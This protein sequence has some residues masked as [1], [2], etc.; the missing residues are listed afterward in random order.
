M[1]VEF[2]TGTKR[3]VIKG[4]RSP[5]AGGRPGEPPPNVLTTNVFLLLTIEVTGEILNLKN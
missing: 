3:K 1:I 4:R 5:G 2:V